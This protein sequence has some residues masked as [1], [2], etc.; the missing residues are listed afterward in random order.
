MIFS[1]FS[2]A[3]SRKS[4]LAPII[5]HGLRKATEGGIIDNYSKR[6]IMTEPNCRPLNQKGQP[7]GMEKFAALFL[8]FI[9]GCILSLVIYAFEIVF[10]PTVPASKKQ[11]EE[12]IKNI[13]FL[14]NS[15]ERLT[16][17][18]ALKWHLVEEVELF[19]KSENS[20][21]STYQNE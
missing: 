11:S 10:K 4:H 13:D 9:T 20:I 5:A 17:D 21:Q 12:I 16:D 14:V 6:Y 8:F 3:I 19:V 2:L 1:T 18:K 15:L 7:I